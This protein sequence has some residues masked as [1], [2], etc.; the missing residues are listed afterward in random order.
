MRTIA[1]LASLL[2]ALPLFAQQFNLWLPDGTSAVRTIG[3]RNIAFP[4]ASAYRYTFDMTGSPTVARTISWD[5]GDGAR[6]LSFQE[7]FTL[8]DG[9]AFT[10][11]AEDTAG[12]I[13]L[14]E[15]T[16][17]VEGEGTATRLFKLINAEDA[18]RTL[19]FNE[20]FTIGDGNAGTLTY[21]GASKTLTVEDTSVL[22]QDLTSDA[23]PTF[24][25]V[26]LGTGE[27]VTGS[28]NR[29]T[30]ALTLEIGGTAIGTIAANNIKWQTS[31]DA[32]TGFQ[33]LDADGGTPI[34]NVDTTNE[35][36]GVGTASPGA[37]LDVR[38]AAI[39]NEDGA[40]NDFRV[41]AVGIANALFLQGSSGRLGIGTNAPSGL[42][43]LSASGPSCQLQ[44]T[45]TNAA[46]FQ[47]YNTVGTMRVGQERAAGGALLSGSSAYA[48]VITTTNSHPLQLGS[49]STVGITMDTSQNVGIGTASPNQK[50]TVEGSISLV[51]Q[52]DAA[53]DTAGYGQIWVHD[54]TPNELWFTD[55][56]GT[57]TQ[58]SSHPMDAPK[59]MYVNGPGLDLIGKRVQGYLG[60]IFWQI[61]GKTHVVETFAEY[62]ARRKNEPG[63]VDLV[64][65][66]WAEEQQARAIQKY[67]QQ[68][69]EVALADA[70]ESV[71][72]V[73]EVEGGTQVV[74]AYQQNATTGEMEV[75]ERQGPKTVRRRTGKF[76]SQLKEGVFF[77]SKS[78][79]FKRCLS[80]SEA[81]A[82]IRPEDKQE[83]PPWIANQIKNAKR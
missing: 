28:I 18:A 7:N 29:A 73:E 64:A 65:R 25:G 16:F 48:G 79:K 22:N 36:C 14:D 12:S 41:E 61:P 42:L 45:S 76:K 72:I 24:A 19:T 34:L 21:S 20:D 6:T 9:S 43:H 53:A 62:N 58:I 74:Y 13:V 81:I 11:T 3:D 8:A 49:N 66:D 59:R 15:Q 38:G 39:F 27:L 33:V 32:T 17:E 51:E 63:H 44:D 78:G 56:A 2:F 80:E 54:T 4:S 47:M 69:K 26:A 83:L 35:R 52:A 55:D 5:F 70:F 31:T 67:L 57:D 82:E 37:T 71:E 30:G 46:Y 50:L 10:L 40:D 1:F 75:V 23:T 77:C 60:K 68:E